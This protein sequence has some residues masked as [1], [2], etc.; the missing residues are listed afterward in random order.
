[1]ATIR[2]GTAADAEAIAWQ[3]RQMF[4]DAGLA[5]IEAMSA[6]TAN[7]AAWVRPKLEDGSYRAWLAEDAGAVVAGAGIWVME[8]P[9]HWMDAEP[10][11]AYLLNFYTAPTHRGQGLA[12]RM[13]S[14]AIEEAR[15][16]GIKVVTLHA[17]KFG[18]PIYERHGFK[19]TTEMMLR[20][21]D[22]GGG[23]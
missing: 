11:R 14:L 16:R 15:R 21:A 1:M 8:F 10:A 3:R 23:G 20:L 5:E 9:P 4:A 7:F 12:P 17:S 19:P 22:S 2:L 18:R 13:L 6:M